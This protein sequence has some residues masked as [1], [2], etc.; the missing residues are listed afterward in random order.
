MGTETTCP[1]CGT[2]AQ[3]A[4]GE[5]ESCEACGQWWVPSEDAATARIGPHELEIQNAPGDAVRGPFD[6]LDLRERLYRGLLT[7]EELVRPIGGRFR[8][9]RS[10]P[11][12][13]AVLELRERGKPRPVVSR[14]AP[15]ERV[16]PSASPAGP[17]GG[18]PPG[19]AAPA[20]A[21][22]GTVEAPDAAATAPRLEAP[23]P[24]RVVTLVVVTSVVGAVVL[25]VAMLAY[26]MLL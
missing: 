16:A 7:G 8:A 19:V 6:R 25:L 26:S 9:L 15:K 4:T 18:P 21:P 13:S 12:F 17:A 20:A 24:K 5:P 22:S 1:S 14:R 11:D 23:A 3:A 2:P 10:I